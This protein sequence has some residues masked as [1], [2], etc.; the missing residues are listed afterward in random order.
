MGTELQREASS[1]IWDSA[2]ASPVVLDYVY[3]QVDKLYYGFARTC[4]LSSCAFWMVYD[5]YQARGRLEMRALTD[6]WSYSKQTINSALKSLEER[7]VIEIDYVEGSRK[8]KMVALTDEG[9]AFALRSLRPA[10]EAELRAFE[11]LSGE[12]REALVCLLKKYAAALEREMNA[13]RGV[14]GEE[15]TGK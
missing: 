11:S 2:P 9:A 15:G 1:R 12:E 7:G 14:A 4:G 6:S 5:L 3:N 10:V 13:A 8:N